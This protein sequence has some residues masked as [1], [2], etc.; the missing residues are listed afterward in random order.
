MK[1]ALA[2]ILLFAVNAATV[3]VLIVINTFLCYSAFTIVLAVGNS[4]YVSCVISFLSILYERKLSISRKIFW[5]TAYLP[6]LVCAV[7]DPAI[8]YF[9]ELVLHKFYMGPGALIIFYS[10]PI[11]CAAYG[12]FGVV[13]LVVSNIIAK[14]KAAK[15]EVGNAAYPDRTLDNGR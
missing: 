2:L 1:K 7:L 10:V 8:G 6:V 3:F 4:L 11:T 15:Q 9:N 13:W 12:L 5:L 14:R